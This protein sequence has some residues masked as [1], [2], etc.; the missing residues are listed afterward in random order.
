V[1]MGYTT[2][3]TDGGY[4]GSTSALVYDLSNPLAPRRAGQVSLP[5]SAG[6]PYYYYYCGW[7]PWYGYYWSAPNTWT[8]TAQGLVVLSQTWSY[9]SSTNLHATLELVGLDLS[10]PDQPRVVRQAAGSWDDSSYYS[11]GAS[12][13]ADPVEPSSFYLSYRTKVGQVTRDGKVFTQYRYYAQ[14]WQF[15]AAGFAPAEAVNLPGPLVNTWSGPD[16]RRRFLTREQRYTQTTG[17]NGA[18]TYSADATLALLGQVSVNGTPAAQLDDVKTWSGMLPSALVREGNQLI[19]TAQ[20]YSYTYS[21]TSTGTPSWE[22][23]SDRLMIFDLSTNHL[24]TAYDQP[25]KAY[26]LRI[27]GVQKDRAFLNLQGDGIVVV[28]VSKPTAPI[29]VRFLR[30]LGYAT[31]LESFGD[32]VYVAS[33]YFGLAHLSLLDPPNL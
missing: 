9:S 17:S 32:D 22:Q 29:G 21:S 26:A 14:R 24:D 13:T 30:T 25:T 20:P 19:V 3:L 6:L 5:S 33:G 11:S 7:G 8:T 18:I 12:L 27:M 1:L 15:T 10:N 16:G 4:Y 31:H 28:D 23:T 2:T